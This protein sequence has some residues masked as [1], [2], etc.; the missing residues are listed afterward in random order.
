MEAIAAV[1][2]GERRI[3]G[4]REE[5]PSVAAEIVVSKGLWRHYPESRRGAGA[6]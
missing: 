1:T 5:E 4:E 3:A 6:R 2:E